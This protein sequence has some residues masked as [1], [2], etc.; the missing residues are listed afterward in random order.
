MIHRIRLVGLTFII[1][2]QLCFSQSIIV[3]PYLQNASPTQITIMW[4]VDETGT[5]SVFIGD[6]PFDQNIEYEST[7]VLGNGSTQIHT[8]VIDGLSHQRKYYYKIVMEDLTESLVY[9]FVTPP[10]VESNTTVQ[11]VAMSDMQR[12]GSHPNKFN[13]IVEDGIISIITSQSGSSLTDLEAVLIPGD[14]VPTGGSYN[15][16]KDYFFSQGDS[17]LSHVP[18][19]PVLGNH[20]YFG[21]GGQANFLKYFDLPLNGPIGL[22][23]RT[24]YK[25]L[26]NIRIIGFDSNANG[27]DQD[28]QLTWLE[29]LLVTTCVDEHIDFVFAELHHPHLSELWTPGESSFTGEIIDLLEDF[30][31]DC[32]KA[33]I[34]F[35]GHTHAYSRGQ[36]R[37]D[38]HLWVNVA[39]AGGAIDNWGEFPNADYDEFVKSQ[40]E[41]GFVMVEAEAGLDPTF[42][43]TRYGRG[44]QDVIE[45]NVLRDEIVIR[46]KENGP[47]K[48]YN[49]FPVNDEV[50][51]N[52]ILLQASQFDDNEDNHQASHWQIANENDFT[53]TIVSESWMQSE[54]WYNEINTQ[55][56]DDLTNETVTGLIPDN[57]YYWRV[58]YRDQ[59]LKWSD[60]ST[61]TYFEVIS[62]DTISANLIINGNAEDNINGWIG[63]IE[64]LENAECGSVPSFEG[65]FNFAVGGVCANE[66][67]VGTAYQDIDLTTY[68]NDIDGDLLSI[69]YNGYMRNFGGND[70]PE[71][72]IEFYDV[73][74]NLI[75]STNSISNANGTWTNEIAIENIPINSRTCRIILKGTRLAGTDNDSYFDAFSLYVGERNECA[76]CIGNSNIDTDAD[77][78]CDDVDC[79]DDDPTI[80]PGALELCDLLDNNCDGKADY[81]D[82]I[83]WIG[84]GTLPIWSDGKN[85]N[86]QFP[87]L[88][89]QY[90]IIDQN[91]SVTVDGSFSCKGITIAVGNALMVDTNNTLI[92]NGNDTGISPCI[93]IQGSLVN[94][95]KCIAKNSATKSLDVSG[96]L[97][98]NGVLQISNTLEESILLRSGAVFNGTGKVIVNE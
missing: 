34:H 28:T 77:G 17:L 2:I 87:P 45:D 83:R 40:D 7:S 82:T 36:S 29:E 12:D 94:Y 55:A 56:D 52:C 54:N 66:S 64:S 5:G 88:P 42:T 85:W 22:E 23:E 53:N 1:A 80:Y 49:V 51:N 75:S 24:W 14:L 31:T 98:N 76:S 89:C 97:S 39:T 93:T 69:F 30:T 25:D 16:W 13:E 47:Q 68:A 43:L 90:V 63:D 33:S 44:D 48:P 92:V 15:H 21:S 60:W 18:F 27:S 65:S 79:D 10:T 11:L 19:Y 61:P 9:N 67:A 58:R 59:Y 81:G 74:D 8:A 91:A 32:N 73:S 35:F 41:Y 6:T 84:I 57:D 70:T 3:K 71:A 72:Y 20:E 46:N 95:G 50:S 96:T 78:Y 62:A 38:Q 26:S 37:D 86:Q 4:E